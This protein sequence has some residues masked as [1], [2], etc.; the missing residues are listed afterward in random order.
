MLKM[1]QLT[2]ELPRTTHTN[3]LPSDFWVYNRSKEN[4]SKKNETIWTKLKC[5]LSK[6]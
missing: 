4:G 6:F 3:F 2:V 1:Q 5:S